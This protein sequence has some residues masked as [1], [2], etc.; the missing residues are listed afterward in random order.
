M[1]QKH[2]DFNPVFRPESN[3]YPSRGAYFTI[4]LLKIPNSICLTE[5]NCTVNVEKSLSKFNKIFLLGGRY[6]VFPGNLL[7]GKAIVYDANTFKVLAFVKSN[8]D[9]NKIYINIK[10]YIYYKNSC[11]TLYISHELIKN[12]KVTEKLLSYSN[13][14]KTVI[15]TQEELDKLT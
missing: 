5:N 15:L 10:N 9:P 1:S 6:Y 12:K 11:L 2:K 7:V 4:N 14:I 8:I 3:F 13:L